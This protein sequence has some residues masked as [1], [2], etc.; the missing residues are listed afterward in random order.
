MAYSSQ[1]DAQNGLNAVRW[2]VRL[3]HAGMFVER[4]WQA[5][6]PLVTVCLA[7]LAALMLGLQDVLMIELVWVGA[8][9]ALFAGLAALIYALTRFRIPSRAAALARLD[10]ALPGRPIE[11]LMDGQAIGKTDPASL[12]VWRAHQAR[13]VAHAADATPVP[14]DLRIARG[15]ASGDNHLI[16]PCQIIHGRIAPQLQRDTSL[17]N[18]RAVIIHQ[19]PEF[20]FAGNLFG[21][22]QLTT[23]VVRAIK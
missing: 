5:T 13:M 15:H 20:F 22:V 19:A 14:A 17:C 1:R 11:A 9:M 12:V 8:L 18:C 2:P 16:K 23:N 3:T 21:H 4:L 10:E 6:W 7:V